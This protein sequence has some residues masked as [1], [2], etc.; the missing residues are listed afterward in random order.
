M[1]WTRQL[2]F[3]LMLFSITTIICITRITRYIG[4]ITEY[5]LTVG[6]FLKMIALIV[7]NMIVITTPITLI[8][9]TIFVMNKFMSSNELIILQNF[10]INKFNLLKPLL[11]LNIIAMLFSY[12]SYLYYIYID[13]API[14]Y[15]SGA[16]YRPPHKT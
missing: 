13:A 12:K 4:Y 10:S 16:M 1:I 11:I 8:I 14:A 6:N 9:S 5:G 2:N 7:P 15:N 3:L